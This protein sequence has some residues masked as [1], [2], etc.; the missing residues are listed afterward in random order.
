MRFSIISASLVLIFANVK[1]FNEEEI[2]EIFCGVPKKLVSR[3]NQCLI[4]HGPEIIK[5]NYE[6]I[7][8]C[9]KGHLGS[10]TESAME[11]VCNKKNVDIS[12]KRCISDKIS[13]EMKEFDRRARLEVWDVLYVC[14]FKA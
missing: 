6:I 9:M 14:I 13:E 12:I 10:E 4:D 3:Y 11:Y 1:A 8:S 2:L 5:K 7:N